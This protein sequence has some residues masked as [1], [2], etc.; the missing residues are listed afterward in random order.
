VKVRSGGKPS[1]HFAGS[2]AG[3]RAGLFVVGRL[4]RLSPTPG[5]SVGVTDQGY[6]LALV[7]AK[8][9]SPR[10][11]V[12]WLPTICLMAMASLER[13]AQRHFPLTMAKN[14][15]HD[16]FL[17]LCPSRPISTTV[18][19]KAADLHTTATVAPTSCR[20]SRFA[21]LAESGW[22]GDHYKCAP[23]V[24]MAWRRSS[25]GWPRRSRSYHAWCPRLPHHLGEPA[26]IIG[27]TFELET[28]TSESTTSINPQT[29]DVIWNTAMRF[30][31]NRAGPRYSGGNRVPSCARTDD[32]PIRLADHERIKQAGAQDPGLIRPFDRTR[33][34]ASINRR[35]SRP[36]G[37]AFWRRESAGQDLRRPAR[38]PKEAAR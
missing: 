11:L 15:I 20:E 9:V 26:F 4:E 36:A 2:T 31:A 34:S 8:T 1:V 10:S 37:K 7:T 18:T 35:R 27:R 5:P 33:R 38:G 3:I 23:C 22:G 24:R 29:A 14:F 6:P 19:R 13:D 12:A 32:P 28:A 16:D 30:L 21:D 17:L 25:G